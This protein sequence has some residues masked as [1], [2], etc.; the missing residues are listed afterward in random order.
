MKTVKGGPKWDAMV[1]QTEQSQSA[2][3][4]PIP[5]EEARRAGKNGNP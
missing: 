2:S 1:R 4:K 5:F 3:E